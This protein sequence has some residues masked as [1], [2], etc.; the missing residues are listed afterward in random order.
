MQ[1]LIEQVNN[2]DIFVGLTSASLIA[3]LTYV[4][5][6]LP[7]TILGFIKHQCSL[8]MTVTNDDPFFD[9]INRWIFSTGSNRTLRNLKIS[10]QT[11]FEKNKSNDMLAMVP[12]TGDHIIFYKRRPIFIHKTLEN[13]NSTMG[14]KETITVRIPGRSRQIYFNIIHEALKNSENNL[15]IKTFMYL[16]TWWQFIG[17]KR[18]RDLHT[19]ILKKGQKERLLNDVLNFLN[20]QEWYNQRGIPYH[21]GYMLYGPPG[22]GKTSIIMAIASYF[23]LPIYVI[24]INSIKNDNN[25]T[26]ALQQ[27]P[28]KSIIIIED[29][30]GCNSAI[31]RQI[32]S[33]GDVTEN[34]DVNVLTES[35]SNKTGV[36]ISGLLNALDGICTIEGRI[37]FMTTNHINK[38]DKALIRP[39]RVD[40]LEEIGYADIDQIDNILELFYGSDHGITKYKENML[41]GNVTICEIQKDFIIDTNNK[42]EQLC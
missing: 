17:Y 5:K 16:N 26:E 33:D 12:A 24:N 4:L 9:I 3:S 20:S 6:G 35:T 38:I 30:D 21:R 40:V 25:L 37:V 2:N 19:I 22:T 14:F 18:R 15:Y 34:E 39:G 31:Q 7:K 1:W 41:N 27:P 28:K 10:T 32:I 8:S 23:Q 11:G 13:E 42:K 36:T 29:I